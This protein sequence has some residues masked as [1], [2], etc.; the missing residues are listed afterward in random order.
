MYKYKSLRCIFAIYFSFTTTGNK[1][2]LGGKWHECSGP[3]LFLTFIRAFHASQLWIQRSHKTLVCLQIYTFLF[4]FQF[5]QDAFCVCLFYA[6]SMDER[7]KCY[8]VQKVAWWNPV[9]MSVQLS[10]CSV[11]FRNVRETFNI[12]ETLLLR[13]N[14]SEML[15]VYTNSWLMTDGTHLLF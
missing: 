14:S 9:F 3:Q 1:S 15:K 12:Q 13:L 11:M 5:W 2:C 6:S 7:F 8:F 10:T 4:S